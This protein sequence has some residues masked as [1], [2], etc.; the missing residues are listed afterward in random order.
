MYQLKSSLMS[1]GDTQGA[2]GKLYLH[3]ELN[4]DLMDMRQD[5]HPSGHAGPR[6]GKGC[7]GTLASFKCLTSTP[8]WLCFSN[9]GPLDSFTLEDLTRSIGQKSIPMGGRGSIARMEP[10]PHGLK[11]CLPCLPGGWLSGWDTTPVL[12]HLF[13]TLLVTSLLSF[14]LRLRNSRKLRAVC[15][16][17]VLS[18]DSR[19]WRVLA[20]IPF[21]F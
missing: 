17:W 13:F 8:P 1:S 10:S 9:R 15:S 18:R 14:S 12:S 19:C 11:A 4:R 7:K 5:W 2:F 16:L 20:E 6:L 21:V 3:E